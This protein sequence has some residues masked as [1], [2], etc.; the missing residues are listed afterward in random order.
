MWTQF[1]MLLLLGVSTIHL[2]QS[3]RY[4][5]SGLTQQ[6][7]RQQQQGSL[8]RIRA[9]K[10]N[11]QQQGGKSGKGKTTAAVLQTSTKPPTSQPGAIGKAVEQVLQSAVADIANVAVSQSNSNALDTLAELRCIHG[12]TDVLIKKLAALVNEI[13][14]TSK[15]QALQFALSNAHIG[16][17]E[18]YDEEFSGSELLKSE[19]LVQEIIM[20]F[21]QD[22]CFEI[23]GQLT[24][25]SSSSP[26]AAEIDRLQSD[27]E[28]ALCDQIHGLTGKRP[29]FVGDTWDDKPVRV[30]YYE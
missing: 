17:F 23:S 6:R 5:K 30:I 1:L 9:G 2:V 27:F 7:Y 3:F 16:E 25:Y 4:L 26:D 19:D 28:T 20:A 24:R 12:S 18:F 14:K 21:L 15:I 29:R 10:N 22:T 13:S 8:Q 11:H